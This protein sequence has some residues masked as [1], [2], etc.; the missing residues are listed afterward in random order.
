MED[1]DWST[2]HPYT[3]ETLQIQ[4]CESLCKEPEFPLMSVILGE[5]GS[6]LSPLDLIVEKEDLIE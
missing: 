2:S 6:F 5:F 1:T 4:M 3:K